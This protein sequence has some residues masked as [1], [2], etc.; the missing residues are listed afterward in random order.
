MSTKVRQFIPNE[1]P[2]RPDRNSDRYPPEAAAPTYP[3]ATLARKTL[4]ILGPSVFRKKQKFGWL[5][6]S[7]ADPGLMQKLK[8][9]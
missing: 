5:H 6:K 8:S 2:N 4:R 3:Q 1:K 9:L 7:I